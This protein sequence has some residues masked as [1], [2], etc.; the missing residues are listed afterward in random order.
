[1]FSR[2]DPVISA[3]AGRLQATCCRLATIAFV[4]AILAG[5]VG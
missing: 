4:F 2:S 5:L 3:S 1:M